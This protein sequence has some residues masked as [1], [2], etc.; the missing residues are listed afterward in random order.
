MYLTNRETALV[1]D[2][3][4]VL[5][6]ALPEDLMRREIGVRMLDLLRADYLGS[7]VWDAT[8]KEFV[9]RVALNMSDDNLSEYEHYYQYHDTVTPLLQNC[10]QAVRVTDVIPQAE[11][12]RTE[13]FND[14]LR[15]DGLHWGMDVF[16]WSGDTNIGDLRI[17]RGSQ[18]DN[19]SDHDGSRAASY[20]P[21]LRAGSQITD[22]ARTG[23][24]VP[25]HGRTPR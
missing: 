6:D 2:I 12:V 4:A 14:F 5:A 15:R 3:F 24:R 21:D 16:A 19:F 22:G 8:K 13:L 17:W 23:G 18:R 9:N 7:Y 11:L 25:H 20:A 10:R 1:S